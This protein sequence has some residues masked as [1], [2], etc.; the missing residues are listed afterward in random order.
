MK[1]FVPLVLALAAGYF[2]G[3]KYPMLLKSVN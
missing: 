3:T 1:K 2:I